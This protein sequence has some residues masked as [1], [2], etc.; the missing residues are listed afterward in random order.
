MERWSVVLKK[1][2]ESVEVVFNSFF[3]F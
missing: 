3:N 1:K 2:I